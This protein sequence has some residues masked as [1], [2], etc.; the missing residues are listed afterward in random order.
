MA[1]GA[2]LADA[3]LYA[4]GHRRFTVE[5]GEPLTANAAELLHGLVEQVS[6]A[7]DAAGYV[8]GGQLAGRTTSLSWTLPS[9]DVLARDLVLAARTAA[10]RLNPSS[11]VITSD[12]HP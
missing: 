7:V 2:V 5:H 6:A 11:W 8:G 3:A 12:D 9:T 1:A 10:D 4:S